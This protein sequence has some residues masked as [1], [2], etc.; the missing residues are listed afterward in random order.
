MDPRER[1]DIVRAWCIDWM[2]YQVESGACGSQRS[3]ASR[4]GVSHVHVS[5]ILGGKAGVGRNLAERIAELLGVQYRDLEARALADFP[6]EEAHLLAATPPS[7]L[8]TLPRSAAADDRYP[9]RAAA[10]VVWA[11]QQAEE[12]EDPALVSSATSEVRSMSLDADSDPG[13]AHWMR[14]L[15]GVLRRLKA[16]RL[17]GPQELPG[18]DAP[19]PPDAGPMAALKARRR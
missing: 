12:A 19:P 8:A 16:D 5:N 4:L 6:V 9:S 18:R 15:A 10:L 1:Y 2:R 7:Q 3:F 17:R 11:S 13:A 14:V